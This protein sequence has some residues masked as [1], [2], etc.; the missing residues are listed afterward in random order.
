MPVSEKIE[1]SFDKHRKLCLYRKKSNFR[2]KKTVRYACI[3]KNRT[4]L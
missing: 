4:L 2:L 3:G 1:F